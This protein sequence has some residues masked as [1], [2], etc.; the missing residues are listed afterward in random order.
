MTASEGV[1]LYE[2]GAL[3]E[4]LVEFN[5]EEHKEE[6]KDLATGLVGALLKL[7]LPSISSPQLGHRL[8]A[9]VTYVPDDFLRIMVD[10]FVEPFGRRLRKGREFVELTA[11]SYQGEPI[12]MNTKDLWYV[13]YRDLALEIQKHDR[14]IRSL[15][16]Y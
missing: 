4:E 11:L 2:R 16:G 9:I 3:S 15:R 12:Y 14:I 10:P 1:R 13:N 7:G 8:P 5:P 6:W